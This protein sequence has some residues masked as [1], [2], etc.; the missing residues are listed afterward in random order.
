MSGAAL[1]GNGNLPLNLF[2]SGTVAPGTSIGTL[3]VTGNYTQ[4]SRGALAI[5]ISPNGADKLAVTGSAKLDGN[6]VV[7]PETGSYTSG[8]RYDILTAG[9]GVSGQFGVVDAQ[10]SER[11]GNLTA[12][13]LYDDPNRVV[14]ALLTPAEASPYSAAQQQKVV[15][16][17]TE[18]S[19]RAAVRAATRTVQA[20]VAGIFRSQRLASGTT[21]KGGAGQGPRAEMAAPGGLALASGAM[22]AESG[23][24]AGGSGR[25][26]AAWT[27]TS[28]SLLR[29]SEGIGRYS[30]W[31]NVTTLGADT[32]LA[33]DRMVAGVALG[34]NYS[35][36]TLEAADGATSAVAG[37]IS[38]YAGY[39]VS[40]LITLDVQAGYGRAYN[41]SRQ[42]VF[43]RMVDADYPSSRY[44]GD[45]NLTVRKSVEVS[46]GAVKS[47]EFAGILG[48][49]HALEDFETYTSSDGA[50]VALQSVHLG[51][52]KLAGEVSAV[53]GE[54]VVPYVTLGVERDLV[55][56]NK[57]DAE[58][59][60]GFG[61][62]G[63]Q[64]SLTDSI[65][66]GAVFNTNFGRGEEKEYQVGANL[67]YSF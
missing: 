51:T 20:R 59:T 27:D 53:I 30:G 47:V 35:D 8:T 48:Y 31:L 43:G 11:L 50:K 9:G 67:R 36:L 21:G 5:E 13:P 56:S 39:Q 62:L 16:E 32:R 1:M 6:L 42:R 2:N 3:T 37:T 15:S 44:F 65:D 66:L 24:A 10:N 63:I 60:G 4:D 64:A 26:M 14:L 23:M 29:D 18:A 17:S 7:Q 22:E 57:G 12:I 52:A 40:D 33:D 28:F 55:N 41:D 34:M 54:S 58:R 61:G 45:A 25:G 19:T 46:A 38:L 49:S